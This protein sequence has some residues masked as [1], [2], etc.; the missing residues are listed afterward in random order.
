M[1][2]SY[3][4]KYRKLKLDYDEGKKKRDV[5]R[6]LLSVAQTRCRNLNE[7]ISQLLDLIIE[8]HNYS[9]S[10]ESASS[11]SSFNS[12]DS[13][14]SKD[15]SIINSKLH[16]N[17]NDNVF[18]KR[19]N[20]EKNFDSDLSK[21]INDDIIPKKKRRK[22]SKRD[23][24]F[25]AKPIKILPRDDD[26][27]LKL[28]VVVGKSSNEVTIIS[29]GK[30]V[31]ERDAYHSQRYIWPVGFESKKEYISMQDPKKR[32]IYTNRILDGGDVPIFEVTAEDL[33]GTVFRANSASGAWKSVLSELSKRGSTG[34]KTH[35]SGPDFFGLSDLGVTKVIQELPNAERCIRYVKQRW[36]KDENNE[37]N[38][39]CYD[40]NKSSE[41]VI[42]N[43]NN[44]IENDD[45]FI[46]DNRIMDDIRIIE[47]PEEE[48]DNEIENDDED[49]N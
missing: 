13:E 35:A 7:E 24:R 5:L 1:P 11:L 17:F 20:S 38:E 47:G 14:S 21:N 43:N 12:S 46:D 48:D 37:N 26:G 31:H 40:N 28:P 39:N 15:S 33:P 4:E 18:K 41:K 16:K 8:S 29:I 23:T 36:I 42:N 45:K 30:I 6:Q 19:R 10:S 9:D 25:D 3:K 34:A 49:K 27:N 32:T 44:E 22:S 2:E